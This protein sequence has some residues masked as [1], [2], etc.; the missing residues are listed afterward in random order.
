MSHLPATTNA[1]WERLT[2]LLERSQRDNR[3]LEEDRV[4][5]LSQLMTAWQ[6]VET[7]KAIANKPTKKGSHS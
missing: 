6:L 7:W 2:D 5:L 3:R 4:E 1:E